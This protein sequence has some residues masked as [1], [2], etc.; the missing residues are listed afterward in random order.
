[1]G[2]SSHWCWDLWITRSVFP[3]GRGR[4]RSAGVRGTWFFFQKCGY[5]RR[6]RCWELTDWQMTNGAVRELMALLSS[7]L[8]WKLNFLESCSHFSGL[9]FP[10]ANLCSIVRWPWST[11]RQT[12]KSRKAGRLR[13]LSDARFPFTLLL[14]TAPRLQTPS[15]RS[16]TR[17]PAVSREGDG[18]GQ[19]Q[20]SSSFS[21]C[22]SSWLSPAL[23][24][25]SGRAF[26]SNSKP[27]WS[28][29]L[30]LDLCAC[31]RALYLF[32]SPHNFVIVLL[33]CSQD[34]VQSNSLTYSIL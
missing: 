10:Q 5:S 9:Q 3:T 24:R 14:H 6:G 22:L 19:N 23:G 32:N 18:P 16:T 7:G 13:C 11:S 4:G 20:H 28:P 30:L 21:T 12:P 2:E 33:S 34:S 1:M 17:K 15:S 29:Q 8:V 27:S 25:F 31:G 26:L